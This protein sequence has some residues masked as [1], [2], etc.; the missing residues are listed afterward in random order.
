MTA[1]DDYLQGI[2]PAQQAEFQRIR[3]IVKQATPE[4]EES[5]SYGILAFKY[6]KRPLLYYGAFAS[7]MSIYPTSDTMVQAI[8]ELAAYR[9]S[10][11]TFRYTKAK[12]MTDKLISAIVDFRL[13]DLR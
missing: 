13:K 8:P 5:V 1:V 6:S 2:T 4:A 11:G 12:P 7:H 9:T 3:S 10:K